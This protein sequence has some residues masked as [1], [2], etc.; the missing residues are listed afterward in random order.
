MSEALGVAGDDSGRDGGAPGRATEPSRLPKAYRIKEQLLELLSASEPGSPIESERVLAERFGV[1]RATI[2]QALKD[3]TYEGRLY[4]LQ[5]RGTFIARPKLTQSLQLTS[6][7]REMTDSGLVP[8]SDLLQ[9]AQLPATGEVAKMLALEE[10]AVVWKIERLRRANGEPMA[11]E[12]LRV[13]ASRFPGIEEKIAA[14]RS[15]YDSLGDYGVSLG[16]GEESIE[17]VL[18][19]PSTAALLAV[20][21]RSPMLRL[22]RHSWD[23]AEQPIEYVESFYRGDRY[24]FVTP[25]RLPGGAG[26][27]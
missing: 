6:H 22:T 3:L 19:S 16:G 4:R 1:A 23:A 9:A 20:E 24:R 10:G 15:F 5:G 14:G 21:P 2:R 7:T 13:P 17:C 27:G 11:L 8:S 25:L 26:A 18:A 12:S